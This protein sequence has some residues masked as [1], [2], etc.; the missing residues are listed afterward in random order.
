MS[1]K[2]KNNTISVVLK[3]IEIKGFRSIESESLRV[4]DG[5]P[6]I[7][8]GKNECGKSN[9]LTAV[10]TLERP[11]LFSEIDKTRRHSYK[12][13]N[14]IKFNCE[15]SDEFIN[16][17]ISELDENHT[18]ALNAKTNKDTLKSKFLRF[19]KDISFDIN[20]ENND[21]KV[22]SKNPSEFNN[23]SLYHV[24][25]PNLQK[26][27]KITDKNNI[28]TAGQ[29]P[30]KPE[31][32]IQ[33]GQIEVLN[34]DA[35]SDIRNIFEAKI[36]D[37][38]PEILEWNYSSTKYHID[39]EINLEE[40]K[41]NPKDKNAPLCNMFLIAGINPD[42]I[43]TELDKNISM[44]GSLV[45]TFLKGI[46]K[47]VNDYINENWEKY[48]E[49]YE[50]V[51]FHIDKD[52]ENITIGIEEKDGTTFD[53]AQRS[54]GFKR[55]VSFLLMQSAEIE[56]QEENNRQKVLVLDEPEI[57][58][59]HSSAN[60]YRDK[61]IKLCE[62]AS[63]IYTTHSISMID[64]HDLRNNVN[65]KKEN[66]ITTTRFEEEHG[67]LAQ[68][69][70]YNS[71]GYTV[72]GELN[73]KNI[74]LEGFR[75]RYILKKSFDN[76]TFFKDKGLC[77]AKSNSGVN[78][79]A[80][81]LELASKEYIVLSDADDDCKK[82]K[83]KFNYDPDLWY[84]YAY[85]GLGHITVEDF[86]KDEFIL[87]QIKAM[88]SDLYDIDFSN[89]DLPEFNK[90]KYI[91]D[92]VKAERKKQVPQANIK[93]ISEKISDLKANLAMNHDCDKDIDEVSMAKLIEK[94]KTKL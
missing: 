17:I 94:L 41:A 64:V 26:S 80:N 60:D 18:K 84:T 27:M 34:F 13:G 77:F 72:L 56:K 35:I 28:V 15:V 71:L 5:K 65:V 23:I 79:V 19:F 54:E 62:K 47:E 2:I 42:N 16:E 83:Q 70:I 92:Y 63:I 43:G 8:V 69:L 90:I 24:T 40:F 49:E 6:L 45:K 4:Q 30:K 81:L 1:E 59:H 20:P 74:I 50:D 91:K 39:S 88:K 82:Y 93:E 52:G 46:S 7:L 48:N 37:K 25:D 44:G 87:E 58:L 66:G 78:Q 22:L 21:I 73:P 38:K 31:T 89:L 53:V 67:L 12:G 57:S 29:L 11:E 61:L 68:E 51:K 3:E 86:L 14:V 33:A 10:L 55:F 36:L 76:D 9:F 32:L 75:D 85:F